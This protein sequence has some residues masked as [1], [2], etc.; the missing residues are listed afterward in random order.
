MNH[1]FI[2]I[3][4]NSL[5]TSLL[6]IAVIIVRMI[7]KKAPKWFS[8]VL[9]GLVAIKLV[10]PF[11]IESV[12]SLV[13]SSKPIPSDIEYSA[14]PQIESGV[15]AINRVVNPVLEQNF[16]PQAVTSINPL[17]IVIMICSIVWIVGIIG[18]LMY[19]FISYLLL[20]RKVAASRKLNKNVYVC[21][22]IVTPFILGILRPRI[23]LPTGISDKNR[24]CILE[25]EMAHLRRFDHLWKPLGFVILAG[26]WFNPLCWGA[27]ILLCK[28]IELAC[29]EKVTRDKDKEWKAT[30]CQALLACNTQ[31]RIIAAC[32]VAF[33]EVSVKDRVKSVLNYKKPAFWIIVIAIVVSVIIAVCFMTNPKTLSGKNENNEITTE[34]S[35]K[36]NDTKEVDYTQANVDINTVPGADGAQIDCGND[37]YIVFHDYYGLFVYNWPERKLQTSLSLASIG[38][39]ATQ[40]DAVCEVFMTEDYSVLI[41]ALNSDKMYEFDF[42]NNKVTELAYDSTRIKSEKNLVNLS[43][44]VEQDTTIWQS[45]NAY[46]TDIDSEK[47]LFWLESG[48]GLPIDLSLH[49]KFTDTD[50][51]ET[52]QIFSKQD[53]TANLVDNLQIGTITSSKIK[54]EVT[55]GVLR[56]DMFLHFSGK[57]FQ[58]DEYVEPKHG[59]ASD[60]WCALG[61]IGVCDDAQMTEREVFENGKLTEYYDTDNH[62]TNEKIEEFSFGNYTGCLYMY[63]LD[64]FSAAEEYEAME[65]GEIE[66]GDPRTIKHWVAFYTEGEGEPLYM[67]FYNCDYFTKEE[68]LE[69]VMSS[70]EQN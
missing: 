64:L 10:F 37:K 51:V 44:Y 57:I 55:L 26:Y 8:C 54:S 20:K 59:Y 49:I 9:W 25:H 31:R 33:G 45:Y 18:L 34:D 41:H 61:G 13:P 50:D 24:E 67:Q 63:E 60:E 36:I 21:D 32:P 35:A 58:C 65:K 11:S 16:A 29:D 27:Y 5:I 7:I 12:F 22:E 56:W 62:M 70:G 38:C 42:I 43:D 53:E 3:L 68:S 23:Y 30:Y 39:D 14:T 28:D 48:S 17:Q 1:I 47:V 69:N 2:E 4:N 66:E 15:D 52:V 40:G 19:S 46:L 6:I